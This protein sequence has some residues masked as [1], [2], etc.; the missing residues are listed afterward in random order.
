MNLQKIENFFIFYTKSTTNPLRQTKPI[1]KMNSF[2]VRQGL[3]LMIPRVFPQWVDEQTIVDVFHKQQL[4]Q[5]YKVSIIRQPD[6]KRRS[7]PIYQ[8]IIYFSAWYDNEIA[9][10]FQQRIYGPKK[11]ARVVYDDPWFWVVFKNTQKRLSNNDKRIMR[12]GL[13]SNKQSEMISRLEKK[14]DALEKNIDALIETTQLQEETRKRQYAEFMANFT[15]AK[16]EE[17]AEAETA[18]ETAD[19]DDVNMLTLA[20]PEFQQY[21][22]K[23]LSEMLSETEPDDVNMKP[24]PAHNLSVTQCID[25][26]LDTEMPE[27][28]FEKPTPSHI[29]WNN[30]N[31]E[32]TATAMLGDELALTEIAMD[33]AEHVLAEDEPIDYEPIEYNDEPIEYNDVTIEYNDKPNDYVPIDYVP[34][35]VPDLSWNQMNL[36]A[37]ATA[38]LGDELALTETAMDVAE[39][40][41]YE[42]YGPRYFGSL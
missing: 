1:F 38:I 23:M 41:L 21:I 12:A 32:A 35:F 29:S 20:P 13:K 7:I 19:N 37:T 4:G 36:E 27:I 17:E 40:A 33:V 39:S 3:S 10:N 24:G 9:Y 31:L 11:Q 18:E 28:K 34:I 6:S 16:A 14:M 5:V 8:A 25:E 42:E 30:L 22:H 15:A 2:P 26:F